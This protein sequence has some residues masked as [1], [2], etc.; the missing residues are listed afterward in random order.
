M[1]EQARESQRLTVATFLDH[2]AEHRHR[3]VGID[4][5]GNEV[6]VDQRRLAA[7]AYKDFLAIRLELDG[8]FDGGLALRPLERRLVGLVFTLDLDRDRLVRL[9][10]AKPDRLVQDTA[11]RRFMD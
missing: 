7:G 8:Q 5:F 4:P 6:E 11:L 3:I 10:T 1:N 2:P 9:G